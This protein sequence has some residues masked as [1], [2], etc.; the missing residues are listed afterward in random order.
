MQ[1]A[2]NIMRS[3]IHDVIFV[4]CYINLFEPFKH[5]LYSARQIVDKQYRPRAKGM[6]VEFPSYQF[7]NQDLKE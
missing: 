2:L 6:V 7:L 1:I 5:E 3:I 4:N